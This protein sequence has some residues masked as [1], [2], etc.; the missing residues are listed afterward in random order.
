MNLIILQSSGDTKS[1]VFFTKRHRNAFCNID[2]E[3]ERRG[4]GGGERNKG[5]GG[6]QTEK[7]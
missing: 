4:G 7:Y 5:K 3:R 2:G 1:V 6:R